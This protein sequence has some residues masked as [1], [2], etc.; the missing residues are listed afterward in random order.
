MPINDAA[1]IFTRLSVGDGLVAQIPAL[2]VSLAAGLLVSKGGTRGA[3][4]EAV[5]GQLGAYPRALMVAACLM[6]LLALVPGLPLLPFGALAGMLAF[7]GYSIPRQLEAKRKVEAEKVAEAQRQSDYEART[8]VK[9][10]LKTEGIEL[11]VGKQL[12]A[13][14]LRDTNEI[15]HR[16]ARM[17]HNVDLAVLHSTLRS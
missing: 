17:R 4:E 10:S 8:S 6:G 5:L 1:D 2:V 15:A 16:V 3:A 12:G 9:E 7:V 13:Q 11:C 14:I